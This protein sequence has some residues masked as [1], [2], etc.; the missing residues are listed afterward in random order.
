M[1]KKITRF[2]ATGSLEASGAS[3]LLQKVAEAIVIISFQK[4]DGSF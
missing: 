4:Q 2:V 1:P 3:A